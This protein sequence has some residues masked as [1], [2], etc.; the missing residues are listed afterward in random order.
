MSKWVTPMIFSLLKS[1]NTPAIPMR[2][3]GSIMRNRWSGAQKEIGFA[4][5]PKAC[6]LEWSSS[7]SK[8]ISSIT[9]RFRLYL[10][11]FSNSMNQKKMFW[12]NLIW[13]KLVKSKNQSSSSKT[14]FLKQTSS[15]KLRKTRRRERSLKSC[16]TS[17][18][19][20]HT[21]KS[22]GLQKF[23]NGNSMVQSISTNSSKR[24]NW[25]STKLWKLWEAETKANHWIQ[26]QMIFSFQSLNGAEDMP[27][28]GVKSIPK[29]R[30]TV[31]EECRWTNSGS[32]KASGAKERCKGTADNC[33]QK[34]TPQT[35]W[36]KAIFKMMSSKVKRKFKDTV[37][38]IN[39]SLKICKFNEN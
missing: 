5:W 24:K 38:I 35:L 19:S 32:K 25:I 33:P 21:L 9:K 26:H 14:I 34:A 11:E 10:R 27:T 6:F 4:L 8:L 30:D 1:L 22:K 2:T 18:T 13:L 3:Q 7:K 16:S 15:K 29:D 37:E 36:K 39:L 17:L 20:S 28:T 23:L 12:K 31:S